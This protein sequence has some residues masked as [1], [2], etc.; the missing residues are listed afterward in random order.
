MWGTYSIQVIAVKKY[1]VAITL[2]T[3]PIHGIDHAFY[4]S[5]KIINSQ[6]RILMFIVQSFQDEELSKLHQ[7]KVRLSPALYYK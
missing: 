2:D 4:N 1:I 3:E 5:L 6:F 7:K